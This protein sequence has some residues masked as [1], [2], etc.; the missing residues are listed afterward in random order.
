MFLRCRICT[1]LLFLLL[2]PSAARAADPIVIDADSSFAGMSPRGGVYPLVLS[3]RNDGPSVDGA[4]VVKSD[5]FSDVLRTYVY[6]LSLPAG[7]S[8]QVIA[9]PAVNAY[10]GQVNV[11]FQGP[12][13][14][15]DVDVHL[16]QHEGVQ[17]GLIGDEVGAL[18]ALRLWK[19][20]HAVKGAHPPA[21]F[22]DC[23]AR[24][25][26]APD[27]AAGFQAL[28]VLALSAGSERLRPEQWTAIR[29]WVL[30]GGS[31]I[32]LGGAG[33][34]ALRVPDAQPLL[35]LSGLRETSLPA[36]VLPRSVCAV[37]L[38]P[39]P[40]ALTSGAAKPSASVL[41][42]QNG[43]VVL[44]R[45][46]VGAGTVLL[47]GFDP[48]Q[49]P[50]RGWAGQHDLW[51]G[52]VRYATPAVSATELRLWTAQEASFASDGA[53]GAVPGSHKTGAV[54]PFRIK[55]PPVTTIAWVFLAFFVLVIPVTYG[56]LKRMG[57]LDWAWVTTPLLSIA[58]AYVLFL[59]T[60]QLYSAGMSRRTAGVVVAAAGDPDAQF[61]GFSEMFFPHGG[62]YVLRIPGAEALEFS[63]FGLSDETGTFT[64]GASGGSSLQP[65]Q[66]VDSTDVSA[67]DFQMGNL[68]FRRI[69]HTEAL[70]LG[71][72]VTAAMARD[73]GGHFDGTVHNGT[74]FPLT[75]CRLYQPGLARCVTLG[76]ILPGSTAT[77]SP[78]GGKH[79][80][81]SPLFPE[82]SAHQGIP[83]SA[84]TQATV[85][86]AARV[87]GA[88]LGPDLGRD[89][90]GPASVLLLVSVPVARKP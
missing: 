90:G 50:L 79:E 36:L 6:P 69:Y 82:M 37:P 67:P 21:R 30:G 68:A 48:L 27:R 24:P 73:A 61:D 85:F 53:G 17:V 28:S 16:T 89:V 26:D 84:G 23:Y 83:Q 52:L 54:D 39:G 62:S 19:P 35:P 71:G 56:V 29:H 25:E 76:D 15:R 66:T 1:A 87:S 38:P 40:F 65:L 3:I 49:Q 75:D 13:R 77:I 31:L 20:P 72:A 8:K 88:R 2:L 64:G 44:A 41:A 46:P 32:L 18:S 74:A 9:Y 11:S 14:A 81:Q 45:Q 70:D 57:R 86:L 58:C 7:T 34:T 43:Q 42:S 22:S 80:T 63:S 55:L 51:Q 12:A 10:A 78:A 59:F 47:V 5:G 4:L 60:V 33:A